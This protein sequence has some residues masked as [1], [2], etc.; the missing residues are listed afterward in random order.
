MATKIEDLGPFG[1][2]HTV[3]V[4]HTPFNFHGLHHVCATTPCNSFL[5]DVSHF[6][7][8]HEHAVIDQSRGPLGPV[9]MTKVPD[10][11]IFSDQNCRFLSALHAPSMYKADDDE[12]THEAI[13][14]STLI[15]QVGVPGKG[16][17][18]PFFVSDEKHVTP[19]NVISRTC[20]FNH[21]YTQLTSVKK[22]DGPPRELFNAKDFGSF[23]GRMV[24]GAD[25][26]L[27]K[28]AFLGLHTFFEQSSPDGAGIYNRPLKLLPEISKLLM[29]NNPE[30]DV[31]CERCADGI[32][33]YRTRSKDNGKTVIFIANSDDF[34]QHA[35]SSHEAG[36]VQ[37]FKMDYA[38]KKKK[39]KVAGRITFCT[40]PNEFSCLS[41][42]AHEDGVVVHAN[43]TVQDILNHVEHGFRKK[44]LERIGC[45][46]FP[47]YLDIMENFK[48]LQ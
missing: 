32:V 43:M 33:G 30:G 12:E 48:N 8:P 46:L 4:P 27:L 24:E 5:Y 37:V 21:I 47:H 14:D 6:L 40:H 23:T 10:G 11:L 35:P 34:H 18:C 20:P 26:A 44:E 39:R 16:V 1:L 28:R 38:R 31:L 15:C 9:F 41:P 3:S 45:H 29:L 2:L 42:E 19:P 25:A 7:E 22:L 17:P 13:P 36:K